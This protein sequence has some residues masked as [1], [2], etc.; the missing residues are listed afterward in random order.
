[1]KKVPRQRISK[2]WTVKPYSLLELLIFYREFRGIQNY[3][4]VVRA[5][6]KTSDQILP[7]HFQRLT[8][9]NQRGSQ[10]IS[11]QVQNHSNGGVSARQTCRKQT[12]TESNEKGEMMNCRFG[13]KH[14][15]LVYNERL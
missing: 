3:V 15:D 9:M 8:H 7:R 1:M 14:S 13:K 5:V 6:C 12:A 11:L 2:C 4:F 10:S